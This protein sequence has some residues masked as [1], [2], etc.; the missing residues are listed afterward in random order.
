MFVFTSQTSHPRST[1]CSAL[2]SQCS[3]IV[4]ISWIKYPMHVLS[5][6]LF[7]GWPCLI[8]IEWR[9]AMSAVTM[10]K[11]SST[12]YWLLWV[13]IAMF[14]YRHC[15]LDQVSNARVVSLSLHWLAL[16]DYDWVT[17]S[18]VCSYDVE[19][20]IHRLLI[21]LRCDRNVPV[22]T[23]HTDVRLPFVPTGIVLLDYYSYV[24]PNGSL[25]SNL[26]YRRTS[27][28]WIVSGKKNECLQG[29]LGL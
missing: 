27:N 26:N 28:Y 18:D 14:L 11:K 22:S 24:S 8:M 25:F 16:S 4:I 23:F 19:Y 17:E 10:S 3:C 1:D 2:W 20:F 9:K 15:F 6:Y 13:V 7:T 5:H 29:H 21:A 12:V